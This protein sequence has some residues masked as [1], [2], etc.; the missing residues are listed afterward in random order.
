VWLARDRLKR[1]APAHNYRSVRP[2]DV[3]RD[4]VISDTEI[5]WQPSRLWIEDPPPADTCDPFLVSHR[6]ATTLITTEAADDDDNDEDADECTERRR[7]RR[8]RPDLLPSQCPAAAS[9]ATAPSTS[10][11]NQQHTGNILFCHPFTVIT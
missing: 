1:H 8:H 9:A 4:G 6:P 2:R 11:R 3:T 7:H 10:E 5:D